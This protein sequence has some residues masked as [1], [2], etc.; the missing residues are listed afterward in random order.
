MP[1]IIHQLNEHRPATEQDVQSLEMAIHAVLP[2][3]YRQ[4]LLRY[5]G[6]YPEPRGFCGGTEVL[7]CFFGFCQ[8]SRCLWCEYYACRDVLPDSVIPI[9]DDPGGN[10]I[11]LAVYKPDCG[12]VYFWDHEA[13]TLTPLAESFTSFLDSFCDPLEGERTMIGGLG[14]LLIQ[15]I[16]VNVDV[17][18]L[19]RSFDA[20]PQTQKRKVALET[21][22]RALP[23][24][25]DYAVESAVI[26]AADELFRAMDA[27]QAANSRR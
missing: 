6:G 17:Q 26:K 15:D 25:G 10:Y 24:G 5:N 16:I 1:P 2:Y 4:F 20:L 19:L 3:D 7:D 11:S 27:E 9:A 22:R 21:L 18:Q 23:A 12:K 14:N 8:K 13:D